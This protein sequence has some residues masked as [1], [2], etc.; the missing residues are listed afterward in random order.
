MATQARPYQVSPSFETSVA[1]ARALARVMDD[2]VRLPGT[3]IGFGLD[4]LVGLVPGVGDLVGAA[5]SGYILY[6]AAQGGVPLSV[7]GRMLANVA[8]DTLLGSVPVIGDL[9]DVAWKSN[10]RNVD[11]LEQYVAHPARARTTSRLYMAAIFLAIALLVGGA[12][13]VAALLIS[14][15]LA[16]AH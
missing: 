7:I 9:F 15:L 1:R 11:L 14:G 12:I 5:M 10:R 16:L 3:R 4:A 2:A 13:A 6:V 8:A